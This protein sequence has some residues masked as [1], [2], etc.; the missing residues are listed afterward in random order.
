MERIAEDELKKHVEDEVS[1]RRRGIHEAVESD[2]DKIIR[3]KSYAQ[4]ALLETEIRKKI[5]SGA[6]GVD[7][8]YWETLLSQLRSHMARQRLKD[9]HRHFLSDKARKLQ[10]PLLQVS[11]LLKSSVTS[12]RR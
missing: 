7:V 10:V 1:G 5:H 11:L 12:R 6:E 2:I 9:R 8:G 3:G 4:L